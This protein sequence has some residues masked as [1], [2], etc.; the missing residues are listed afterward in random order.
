VPLSHERARFVTASSSSGSV[1]RAPSRLRWRVVDIV[2]A[3]VVAVA[4]GVV[5]VGWNVVAE[6]LGTPLAAVLPGFQALGYGIWLLAGPLAML[7]VRKPGAALFAELVAATVSALL[8]AQW[9]FLTLESGLVQGLAAELVFAAFAYR[10]F[11]LPVSV[12]AGAVTGLA[13]A[14]NDL[15]IWY[16]GADGLFAAVY[17]VAGVVSGALLAGLLAWALVRGLAA[18]GALARFAAGRDAERV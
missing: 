10:R 2:V 9:G 15:L 12:L 18:T 17:T 3:A 5:F 7:I 4:C 16:A 8:G 1:T 14:A 13:M 11:G 6:W